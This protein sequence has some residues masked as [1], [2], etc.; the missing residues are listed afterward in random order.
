MK[1]STQIRAT[2]GVMFF[3]II[4]FY[5]TMIAGMGVGIYLI[6]KNFG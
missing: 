6:I 5:L 2:F 4:L 1:Q 3:V